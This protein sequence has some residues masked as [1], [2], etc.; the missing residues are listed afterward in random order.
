MNKRSQ[1]LQ[2]LF[3]TSAVI[4]RLMHA[5]IH[6]SFD[7]LGLAP[8]HLQLLQF[9]ERE[10]PVS[11][12]RLAEHMRLTPGAITQL[13]ESL[14]RAEYVTRTPDAADRRVIN[15]ALTS[16]GGEKI[17]ALSR[18]KQSLLAKVVADL[19]D[20]ELQVFLRVQQKM[21]QYLETSCRPEIK[22]K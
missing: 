2:E 14:V 11:L 22:Q 13:V 8:S 4:Q 5:Y 12:K 17:G 16:A 6:R 18:K 19:N 3:A 20:E 9:I 15:I 1:N 10:Q 21:L 7:E